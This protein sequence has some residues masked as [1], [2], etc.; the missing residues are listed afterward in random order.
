[1]ISYLQIKQDIKKYNLKPNK[2]LGQ[3][4]LISEKFLDDI[5]GAL[6]IVENNVVVEVGPGLGQLT[7]K[8]AE[9]SKKVIAIEKDKYLVEVL[10][11]EINKR[12]IRN[13]KII[14]EDA[15]KFD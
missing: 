11:K 15:L 13:I 4:F 10:N 2:V 1:M 9:K 6:N 8:L 7:F 3:N 5:V 14:N 12:N